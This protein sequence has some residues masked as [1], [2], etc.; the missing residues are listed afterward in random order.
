MLKYLILKYICQC[1]FVRYRKKNL[2]VKIRFFLFYQ[3]FIVLKKS[4]L[5]LL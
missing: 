5:S 4:S 3:E 2:I 1:I